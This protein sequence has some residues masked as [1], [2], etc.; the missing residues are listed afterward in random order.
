MPDHSRHEILGVVPGGDVAILRRGPLCPCGRVRDYAPLFSVVS[1]TIYRV[2]ITISRVRTLL[3]CTNDVYSR[4]M[5]EGEAME[6]E[7][8][9]GLFRPSE[10]ADTLYITRTR[11]ARRR[12]RRTYGVHPTPRVYPRR[13]VNLWNEPTTFICAPR[14][15][16]RSLASLEAGVRKTARRTRRYHARYFTTPLQFR[17][18]HVN[19]N[20]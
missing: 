17:I 7:S 16:V 15:L 20:L 13:S 10:T 19:A 4:V 14:S 8:R 1:P 12:H 5:S 2:V 9:R 18:P 3:S 6:G 11:V